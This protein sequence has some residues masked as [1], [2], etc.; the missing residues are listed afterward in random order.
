MVD[1]KSLCPNCGAPLT[2]LELKCPECGYTITTETAA[3]Q[4]TTD[5]ILSL[6]EKLAAVDKVFSIGTSSKKKASIINAFPLPQ[7]MQSLVR[8]LHMSYSNFEASKESGDK[9]IAMAWLAKAVES[10]RRLSEFKEDTAVASTLEKYTILGDK[11][12]FAKLSGSRAEKRAVGL[13]ALAIIVIAGVFAAL[14]DWTGYYLK[15][16]KVDE[17]IRHYSQKGKTDKLLDRLIE[18]NLYEEAADVM[19]ANGQV[20]KGVAMLAQKGALF[21][22][23]LLAAKTNNADSI[24]LCV[25]EID[26]NVLLHGRE[27]YFLEDNFI[28]RTNPDISTVVYDHNRYEIKYQMNDKDSVVIWGDY[29]GIN[30]KFVIPEPHV[31]RDSP[32]QQVYRE[33]NHWKDFPVPDIYVNDLK[34][35]SL[36]KLGEE[37]DMI[38]PMA[39]R[40]SYTPQGQ[41]VNETIFYEGY[42]FYEVEYQYGGSFGSTLN[43][44]RHHAMIED[45]DDASLPSDSLQIEIGKI[46]KEM[47]LTQSYTDQYYYNNGKLSSI[48]QSQDYDSQG[49]RIDAPFHRRDFLYFD[50]LVIQISTSIDKET[51]EEYTC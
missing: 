29:W 37:Q 43:A 47:G 12:A 7:T 22:A 18:F 31:Y 26:R 27:I 6:Q 33:N 20:V 4:D 46:F 44:V 13:I 10:Y 39:F 24:H 30:D 36:I 32:F 16:G 17:I 41:L 50:N 48:I 19:A 8:L 49:K 51:K 15:R 42:P 34:K 38:H 28:I 23:L 3:S 1:K 25:H 35:I 11:K 2:G 5:S 45:C 21:P 14:F 9:I 40:F